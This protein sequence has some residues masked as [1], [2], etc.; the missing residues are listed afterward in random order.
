[1][2]Y[3]GFVSIMYWEITTVHNETCYVYN[4]IQHTAMLSVVLSKNKVTDKQRRE[5]DAWNRQH[6]ISIEEH[7]RAVASFGWT[8]EE[9]RQGR[10]TSSK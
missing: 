9:Y 1:M 10:K 5:V 2:R 7:N 4:L 3:D 8:L 6:G